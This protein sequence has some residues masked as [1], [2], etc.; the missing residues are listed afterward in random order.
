MGVFFI[1]TE[2][3]KFL[4]LIRCKGPWNSRT[5]KASDWF[6]FPLFYANEGGPIKQIS[7][8]RYISET[9]VFSLDGKKVEKEFLSP[10]HQGPWGHPRL[11]SWSASGLFPHL[12]QTQDWRKN[13]GFRILLVAWF[14]KLSAYRVSYKES[15]AG[16]QVLLLYKLAWQLFTH[17]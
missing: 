15:S 12:F 7:C 11:R 4:Q 6:H 13:L 1:S 8:N 17:L 2:K 3:E 10:H 9:H 14:H 5:K 16:Y